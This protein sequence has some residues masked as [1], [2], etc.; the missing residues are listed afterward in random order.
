[1]IRSQIEN[2]Y[3][4]GGK[5]AKCCHISLLGTNGGNMHINQQQRNNRG[6]SLPAIIIIL[7]VII[8]ITV[9][10][11][12][13]IRNRNIL[14]KAAEKQ[15][16][17]AYAAKAVKG[18]IAGVFASGKT[19]SPAKLKELG[20]TAVPPEPG[21]PPVE[22]KG[23]DG[24]VEFSGSFNGGNE[25]WSTY[26]PL[27]EEI[28]PKEFS[29]KGTKSPGFDPEKLPIPPNHSLIFANLKAGENIDPATYYFMFSNNSPYGIIAPNGNVKISGGA[30]A[31]SE[32]LPSAKPDQSAGQDFYIFAKN[33]I[34][35]SKKLEGTAITQAK[36]KDAVTLGDLTTGQVRENA[37]KIPAEELQSIADALKD[38]MREMWKST[39][40][41]GFRKLS[42]GLEMADIKFGGSFKMIDT[43]GFSYNK[44]QLI[45]ANSMKIPEKT[46]T[47][48]PMSIKV[49]GDLIMQKN[50]VFIVEGDLKIEG[51][52]FIPENSSLLVMGKLEVNNRVYTTFKSEDYP[53]ICSAI[54][55]KGD[56]LLKKGGSHLNYQ[57]QGEITEVNLSG[58]ECP[59]PKY[60]KK[61]KGK[62]IINRK[63]L[64]F[65]KSQKKLMGKIK[66]ADEILK[67]F[68]CSN[69]NITPGSDNNDLPGI[70]IASSDGGVKIQ[71]DNNSACLAGLII[72]KKD[73]VIEFPSKG[74]GVF[75]GVILS[76]DESIKILNTDYRYYPYYFC[77]FV[78]TGISGGKTIQV[79]PRPHLISSG[80]YKK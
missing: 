69:V 9:T 48:C 34:D 53:G 21:K 36:T 64:K 71:D 74:T 52:L 62:Q 22:F 67:T 42:I 68:V 43:K 50:S 13:H 37:P 6:I 4:I 28:D 39:K 35:I 72:S 55:A 20:L 80:E 77:A 29:F 18:K 14:Q 58:L 7:L 25:P 79:L 11:A 45:W 15:A 57:P 10:I 56:I 41:P 5:G 49:N 63:V 38:S 46:N 27:P 1:V 65:E 40:D 59:F 66:G 47:V 78:P 23:K 75:T 12:L 60:L 17:K 44:E 73:I 51:R 54:I 3:V 70:L 19:I 24:D 33:K 31:T 76:L 16:R 61:A 26:I 30:T 8:T 32:Q 2:L